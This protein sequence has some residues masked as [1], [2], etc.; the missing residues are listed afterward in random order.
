M[1]SDKR[2]TDGITACMGGNGCN[3]WG[4]MSPGGGKYRQ[5]RTTPPTFAWAVL[6]HEC[7]GTG[8]R[9]CGCRKITAEQRALLAGRP[10]GKDADGTPEQRWS[11]HQGRL[12]EKPKRVRKPKLASVESVKPAA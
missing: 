3:G 4:V 6:H 1:C 8:R 10:W 2:C 5:K 9:A 7:N 12:I 11:S